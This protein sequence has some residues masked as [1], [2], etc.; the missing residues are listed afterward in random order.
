MKPSFDSKYTS[1]EHVLYPKGVVVSNA[2]GGINFLGGG[3]G[4]PCALAVTI[5]WYEIFGRVVV[6]PCVIFPEVIGR[7]FR[8]AFSLK[9]FE[10]RFIGCYFVHL[11]SQFID[12]DEHVIIMKYHVLLIW[13]V[14][15]SELVTSKGFHRK[16]VVRV[17]VVVLNYVLVRAVLTINNSRL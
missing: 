15:V 14:L 17:K 6:D 11:A 4:H 7:R 16:V 8:D 2:G 13:T 5:H 3:A 10:M 12:F 9:A 1:I